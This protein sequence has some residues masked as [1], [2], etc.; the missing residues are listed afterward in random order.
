MEVKMTYVTTD[1]HEV[2]ELITDLQT[3]MDSQDGNDSTLMKTR[4]LFGKLIVIRSIYYIAEKYI[5]SQVY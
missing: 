1:S 3:H 2:C 4:H 5:T